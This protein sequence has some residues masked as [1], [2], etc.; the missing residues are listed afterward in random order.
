MT[1][2]GGTVAGFGHGSDGQL[3]QHVLLG[4]TFDFTQQFIKRPRH[5]AFVG[6][7]HAVAHFGSKSRKNAEPLHVGGFVD[8]V[9]HGIGRI[10]LAVGKLGHALVG[11][12]HK[13]FD[14]FVRVFA[15]FLVKSNWRTV[16][17]E[18]KFYFYAFKINCSLRKP[19]LAQ[20]VRQAIEQR[21]HRV[22]VGGGGILVFQ[23]FLRLFVAESF[24]GVNHRAA[25][26]FFDN[27]RVGGHFKNCRKSEFI[28]IGAQ[29][30][31][32]IREFFGQHWH[33]TIYQIYRR[34]AGVRL[35]FEGGVGLHVV[36]HVGNVHAYFVVSVFQILHR[37]R[38]VKIF[39][40]GGVNRKSQNGA[41][42]A[43]AGNFVLVNCRRNRLGFA[44]YVG[45]KLV[46]QPKLG[47]DGVHFGVVV[48]HVAQ[49]F[50]YFALHSSPVAGPLRNL[51]N[52][53]L[54]GFGLQGFGLGYQHFF[55]NAAA[56]QRHQAVVRPR[57]KSPDKFGTTPLEYFFYFPFSFAAA[58]RVAKHFDAHRIA[59]NGTAQVVGI[60]FYVLAALAFNY[61]KGKVFIDVF[62]FTRELV[63]G[64]VGLKTTVGVAFDAVFG[65]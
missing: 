53:F 45:R 28:F 58:A 4:A 12:Q 17:V 54:V 62:E 40:I 27:L 30:T 42:I 2:I 14:E 35:A 64:L 1:Q 47:Q 38:I 6:Y 52:Y 65:G 13:L 36:R 24:V 11:Q 3:L 41:H 43:A 7:F 50:Y 57:A 16:F 29:R 51:H 18:F 23:Y 20:L 49:Y 63:G 5:A 59:I 37:E 56:V 15:H 32:V 48:A 22:V 9:N 44:L 21:Q 25:K 46:R 60:Y 34:S 31:Q 39:G 19:F 10:A 8:A 33:G 55:V 61:Q 26:P